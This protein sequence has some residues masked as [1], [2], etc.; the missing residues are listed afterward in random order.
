MDLRSENLRYVD[1]LLPILTDELRAVLNLIGTHASPPLL[2]RTVIKFRSSVREARA[3]A[4]AQGIGWGQ[5][6][7][8][9]PT[10]ARFKVAEGLAHAA[11]EGRK[12][13]DL[14]FHVLIAAFLYALNGLIETD[15]DANVAAEFV[16]EN[17]AVHDD[18]A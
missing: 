1:S 4:L 17:L 18:G 7:D 9:W 5:G 2:E 6:P 3:L 16:R 15:A 8:N 13:E 14:S 10:L 11:R 12:G